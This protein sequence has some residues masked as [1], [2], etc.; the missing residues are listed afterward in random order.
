MVQRQGEGGVA[1]LDGG[2]H[3]ATG[4]AVRRLEAGLCARMSLLL[5]CKS[6][7]CRL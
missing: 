2:Q 6:H 3:L 1:D 4:G 7:G 5:L